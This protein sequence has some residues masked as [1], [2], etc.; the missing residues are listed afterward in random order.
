MV[1]IGHLHSFMYVFNTYI[2]TLL[3]TSYAFVYRVGHVKRFSWPQSQFRNLEAGLP[4][5]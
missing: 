3:Y 4:Q 1:A 2:V 5:S